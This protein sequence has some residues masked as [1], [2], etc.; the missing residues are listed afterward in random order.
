MLLVSHGS[1]I[2][3]RI[4]L[5][6]E[7][8]GETPDP[9]TLAPHTCLHAGDS[10]SRS[11][12]FVCVWDVQYHFSPPAPCV[13]RTF[14]W[15]RFSSFS[16]SLNSLQISLT[17]KISSLLAAYYDYRFHTHTHILT[18]TQRASFHPCPA[19]KRIFSVYSVR[20]SLAHFSHLCWCELWKENSP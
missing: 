16:Q 17:W 10:S 18:Q 4:Y 13:S 7:K 5:N 9:L 8:L 20:F 6:Q 1:R 2:H 3:E 15:A 11:F 12:V 19:S 14:T